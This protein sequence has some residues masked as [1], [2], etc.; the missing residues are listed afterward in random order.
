MFTLSCVSFTSQNSKHNCI[1]KSCELFN[2][3]L[4]S[5]SEHSE[6]S[7]FKL[8]VFPVLILPIGLV[9]LLDVKDILVPQ[10]K[11]SQLSIL[12]LNKFGY[13]ENE[14]MFQISSVL[15]NSSFFVICILFDTISLFRLLNLLTISM[16]LRDLSTIK[17]C[18]ILFD[19]ILSILQYYLFYFHNLSNLPKNFLKSIVFEL[20]VW[21]TVGPFPLIIS[22]V[23]IDEAILHGQLKFEILNNCAFDVFHNSIGTFILVEKNNKTSTKCVLLCNLNCIVLNT[24]HL[25]I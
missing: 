25:I 21:L 5:A 2:L 18:F 4:S 8:C 11:L 6:P 23:L 17:L 19:G 13:Q 20:I 14:M 12:K 16:L 9:S 22:N 1:N 10:V 24:E 3:T 15:S 7:A